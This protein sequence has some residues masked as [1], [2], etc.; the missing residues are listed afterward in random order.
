MLT[1]VVEDEEDELGLGN[2][3]EEGR[4][5]KSSTCELVGAPEL[6]GSALTVH[7]D[8]HLVQLVDKGAHGLTCFWCSVLQ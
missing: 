7:C 3:G 2:A 8:S 5:D 6:S 1:T 4:R